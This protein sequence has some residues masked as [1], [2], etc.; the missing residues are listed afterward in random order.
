MQM[1]V[2]TYSNVNVKSQAGNIWDKDI[3]TTRPK[4]KENQLG[5]LKIYAFCQKIQQKTSGP[6]E[7]CWC[8]VS[9]CENAPKKLLHLPPKSC[10]NFT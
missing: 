1:E 10:H 5:I 2:H 3:T 8:Y 4:P 7:C 9:F 6:G